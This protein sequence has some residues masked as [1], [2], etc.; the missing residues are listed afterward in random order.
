MN[1]ALS[2][3]WGPHTLRLQAGTANKETVN[4]L[5]LGEVLAVLSVDAA[6]VK[7]PGLVGD[8]VT[9]VGHEPL[10]DGGV[11]LLGLLDGGD[12]AGADGPDGLVGDD[13]VLPVANLGG[14]SSKLALDHL[15]SLARLALLERLA[16]A[17]DDADATLGSNLSLVGDDLVRLPEDGP[18]LRVAEDGP[19]DATVLELGDADLAG[20]GAVGLVKDVLG[21][22][23]DARLEVLAHEEEVESRRSDH[24]LC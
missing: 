6:A 4:V 19:V 15:D 3:I 10:A 7:D 22:N 16:A 2:S 23:L 9:N 20:E 14:D 13:D 5:L 12:L 24:H 11:N 17:P 1:E 21:G 18:A 8:L